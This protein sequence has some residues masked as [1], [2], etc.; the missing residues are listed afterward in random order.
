M[1]ET[2]K[3]KYFSNESGTPA[4]TFR[5]PSLSSQK[6]TSSE[7]KP[8]SLKAKVT[9]K[10]R[11]ASPRLPMCGKPEAPNP[12]SVLIK[13]R[14]L[15][16]FRPLSIIRAAILSYHVPR[17]IVFSLIVCPATTRRY[18]DRIKKCLER[19]RKLLALH[20]GSNRQDSK[21]YQD[22]DER[23]EPSEAVAVNEPCATNRYEQQ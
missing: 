14:L 10:E 4:G 6:A 23:V 22:Y 5:K 3:P 2:G 13:S 8:C 11:A 15:P 12:I 21:H 9:A 7:R 20:R 19:K 1:L 18:Y 17:P 16:S